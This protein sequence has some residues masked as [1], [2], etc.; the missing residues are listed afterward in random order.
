MVKTSV[1]LPPRVDLLNG[2]WLVDGFVGEG[3]P[4]STS[5]LGSLRES[6]S[7]VRICSN[8]SAICFCSLCSIPNKL[9][10]NNCVTKAFMS[11]LKGA[12]FGPLERTL[13]FRFSIPRSGSLFLPFFDLAPMQNI[14]LFS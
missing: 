6:L 10:S 4:S 13:C 14:S 8:V 3:S 2:V 5:T 12:C 7:Y 9:C 1:S 11:S